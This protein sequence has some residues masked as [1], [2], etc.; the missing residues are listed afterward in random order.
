ML[1]APIVNSLPQYSVEAQIIGSQQQFSQAQP[2]A[3][4]DAPD[5]NI[6]SFSPE[7]TRV[8]PAGAAL[9]RS[10]SRYPAVPQ[11]QPVRPE[12]PEQYF[13]PQQPAQVPQAVPQQQ[14]QQQYV[15]PPSQLQ[16]QAHPQ[17]QIREHSRQQYTSVPTEED[18]RHPHPPTTPIPIL[19]LD[20]SQSLDGSY[21]QR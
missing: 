9:P 3:F 21:K 10:Q 14:I 6:V 16:P 17:P 2:Q 20:K 13:V 15:A 7:R 18:S 8:R 12:V 5:A 1:C 19:R 11:P 4:T